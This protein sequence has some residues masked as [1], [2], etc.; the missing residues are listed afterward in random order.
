MLKPLPERQVYELLELHPAPLVE[1]FERGSD[2]IVE[3]HHSSH[4]SKHSIF[5]A[6]AIGLWEAVL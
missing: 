3:G 4:A 2:I 6:D 1:P 5:D